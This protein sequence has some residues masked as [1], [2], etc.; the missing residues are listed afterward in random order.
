MKPRTRRSTGLRA[1]LLLLAMVALLGGCDGKSPQQPGALVAASEEPAPP[2][3]RWQC[4]NDLEVRC[5]DGGCEAETGDGFTPMSV[6]FD[7]AGTMT[8]CAYSGCWEGSGEVFASGEF[9]VLAGRDLPFTTAPD[10][11]AGGADVLIALDRADAVA[12]LKVGEFAHPLV[13]KSVP[14]GR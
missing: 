5:G 12:T 7:G 8:V 3:E 11:E 1:R 14:I 4:R 2:A 10:P 13:C 9:L 6:D